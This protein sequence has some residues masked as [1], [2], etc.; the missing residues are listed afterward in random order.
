MASLFILFI[1]AA[2]YSEARICFRFLIG[3]VSFALNLKI[4]TRNTV[5]LHNVRA[6]N[7]KYRPQIKGRFNFSLGQWIDISLFAASA[8]SCCLIN[9]TISLIFLFFSFNIYFGHFH[10]NRL[11]LYALHFR[12]GLALLLGYRIQLKSCLYVYTYI[13]ICI[14]NCIF[15]CIH[16]C[17][18]T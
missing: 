5:H 8:R 10:T 4:E 3:L 16:I 2:V 1:L 9:L 12:P 18:H 11:W 13:Y 15:M 14:C 6:H 7:P 17:I